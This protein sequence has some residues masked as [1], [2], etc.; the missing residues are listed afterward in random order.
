VLIGQAFATTCVG[1]SKDLE[2][3]APL[4]VARRFLVMFGVM[5]G[6]CPRWLRIA[7][8]GGFKVPCSGKAYLDT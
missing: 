6:V 1:W 5:F 3:V 4:A 2:S 8:R 7:P